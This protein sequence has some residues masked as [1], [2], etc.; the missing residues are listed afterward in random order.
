MGGNASSRLASGALRCEGLLHTHRDDRALVLGERIETAII[1]PVQLVAPPLSVFLAHPIAVRPASAATRLVD[2]HPSPVLARAL[3]GT[4]LRK[5]GDL[6]GRRGRDLT[7]L[8]G[9]RSSVVK[10]LHK[11]LVAADALEPIAVPPAARP[12]RPAKKSQMRRGPSKSVAPNKNMPAPVQSI[13]FRTFHIRPE[14]RDVSF[15][16][17]ATSTWLANTL[18]TYGIRRFGDLNGR[19]VRE[20]ASLR[21]IGSSQL[22]ELHGTLVDQQALMA[23]PIPAQLTPSPTKSGPLGPLMELLPNPL[24]RELLAHAPSYEQIRFEPFVIRRKVRDVLVLDL[25]LTGPLAK[26][27]RRAGCVRLGDLDGRTPSDLVAGDHRSR[28]KQVR[29]LYGLLTLAA[30]LERSERPLYHVPRH[31]RGVRVEDVVMRGALRRALRLR[32]VRRLGDIATLTSVRLGRGFGLA[33]R[34][35]L[36]ELVD[37]LRALKATNAPF[38]RAID[39][40]LERLT[41]RERN[42]VLLRFGAKARPLMVGAVLARLGMRPRS[43]YAAVQEWTTHLREACDVSVAQSLRALRARAA[44]RTTRL[45]GDDAAQILGLDRSKGRFPRDF[46]LRLAAAM[47]PRIKIAVPSGKGN[48]E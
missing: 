37:R 19:Q 22:R 44:R 48:G 26:L 45:P 30:A 35:Q 38:A 18:D 40:G 41:A 6:A 5:V 34:A 2:L 4:D 23:R 47:A 36:T 20:L 11:R 28:R 16:S 29:Q 14:K 32:G 9:M 12:P 7:W 17:I 8:A 33:L 1:R 42:A 25:P 31:V 43:R 27:L 10:E 13:P 46:Y 39:E 3:D 15:D 21:R 24:R